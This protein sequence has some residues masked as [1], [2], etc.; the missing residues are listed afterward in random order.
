MSNQPKPAIGKRIRLESLPVPTLT[1]AHVDD[2]WTFANRFTDTTREIYERS[3]R[4][5]QKVY[6]IRDH[7]SGELVGLAAVQRY[8]VT[9]EGRRYV[10][11]FG[12]N[13]LLADGYRGL[14][15]IQRLQHFSRRLTP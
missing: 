9:F 15:I 2:I 7:D 4:Q 6:L 3:L 12:G 8:P 1:A 13:V 11:I 14:N 5:K 10:I